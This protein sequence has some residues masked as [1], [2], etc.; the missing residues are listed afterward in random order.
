[1][2]CLLF[3]SVSRLF[4]FTILG[5]D[6]ESDIALDDRQLFLK[7]DR[8]FTTEYVESVMGCLLIDRESW[9]IIALIN[10]W[11]VDYVRLNRF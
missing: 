1:M 2:L 3:T 4:S 6:D 5:R 7:C 11:R 8:S 10:T 9:S